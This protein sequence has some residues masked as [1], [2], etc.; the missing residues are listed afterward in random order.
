[1]SIVIVNL[2]EINIID[3]FLKYI[4]INKMLIDNFFQISKD[5]LNSGIIS[6]NKIKNV[7]KDD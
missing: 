6:F 2:I 5:T 4:F 1:M 3:E 7:S